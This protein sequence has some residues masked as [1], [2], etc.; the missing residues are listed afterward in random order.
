MLI[1]KMKKIALITSFCNTEEK[2]KVL[3]DN[4]KTIKDLGLDVMVFSH[5]QLPKNIN[6][7]IDYTIISKENPIITWPEKTINHWISIPHKTFRYDMATSLVDY[8]YAVLNQIKRMASLALSMDYDSFFIIDY[9]L[10]ITNYVK[11]VLLDNKKNS[12]F[13]AKNVNGETWLIGLRLISLDR[14]HLTRFKNLITKE[15]YLFN[16]TDVAESWLHK[17]INFIP[18]IIEGEPLEDLIYNYSNVDFFDQSIIKGLKLFIHKIPNNELKLI[19][20]DFEEIKNFIIKTEDFEY[21]Y[22][23]EKW[24]EIN[25]PYKEYTSFIVFYEEKEY[26]FTDI[27]S[28]IIFNTFI[29]Q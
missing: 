28:K 15:S 14:E 17:A 7:L 29:K 27:I 24:E 22:N 10:N 12:F 6:N 13:P 26:D 3:H 25:L 2:L 1:N 9:D 11:S 23:V 20:Y 5:F 4:V 8:G 19:F 21:E 16:S 18:G